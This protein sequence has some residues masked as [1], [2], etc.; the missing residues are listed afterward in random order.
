MHR[1][2]HFMPVRMPSKQLTMIYVKDKKYNFGKFVLLNFKISPGYATAVLAQNMLSSII[3]ALMTLALSTFIDSVNLGAEKGTIFRNF[4]FIIFLMILQSVFSSFSVFVQR[5]L[6]IA[7]QRRCE[8]EGTERIA[9]LDYIHIEDKQKYENISRVV[10]DMTNYI[11]SSYQLVLTGVILF[12]RVV[13]IV[14]IFFKY[15][16]YWVGFALILSMLPTFALSYNCGRKVYDF[17]KRSYSYSLQMNHQTYI[18]KSR[19]T[20]NER[21]LFEYSDKIE[22]KWEQLRGDFFKKQLALH[23]EAEKKLKIPLILSWLILGIFFVLL[24][25]TY[26]SGAI[27]IGLL[28]AMISSLIE[29]N[30]YTGRTLLPMSSRVS[31]ING[32]IVDLNELLKYSFKSE[33]LAPPSNQRIHFDTLEFR[34]VTFCYP[35]SNRRILDNI[36]FVIS[37]GKSYAFVGKNG[38]GKST[39]IK[40]ILRMYDD[41]T[42]QILL[43]GKDIKSFSEM[44]I[45]SIFGVLFQDYAKY[46]VSLKENIEL[47]SKIITKK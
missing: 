1:Y 7:V 39:I 33:Y 4:L 11:Y 15:N 17:Y 16:I 41:Y 22:K 3:P 19:E 28:M 38:S 30:G 35:K 29:F 18:L 42:G 14:L 37:F 12:I 44:E 40:L 26:F 21:T 23:Q 2:M 43:N 32:F 25:R 5:S 31:Q 24:I 8:Y 46:Q 34:N 47:G 27:T 6:R 13:S 45:K 36:S 9:A 10:T 20:A